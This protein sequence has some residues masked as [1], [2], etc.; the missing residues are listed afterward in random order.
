[1]SF[2]S[3]LRAAGF[4]LREV[5]ADGRWRRCATGDKPYRRNGAYVLYPDGRGY[6]RNWA[7]DDGVNAWTSN[8]ATQARPIDLARVA[9]QRER[10][11]QYRLQAIRAARAYWQA[12][13]PMH[14]PHPYIE[15]KGLTQLG[16]A[17]LRQHD[18][19]IV[20]PVWHDDRIISVQTIS[21]DG[22][23]RFWPGAP[24]KSG[25]LMLKRSKAG[26]TVFV[27]GLATGL[28]VFQSVRT[29]T[30]AVC[31]DA[32]NLLPVVQR[33]RP[34]GMLCIAADNDHGTQAR[35]GVNPGIAKAKDAA[36][37]VGAGVAWPTGIEG[38]D[39]ADLLREVGQRGAR[40]I[41]RE[42]VNAARYVADTAGSA[43]R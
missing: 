41:E 11:R 40:R 8:V 24:V 42:I 19:S 3:A 28:A 1:M 7:L 30:V 23:K 34:A 43:K 14:R 31:F 26:I 12:A 5:V 32:G 21:P 18:G 10:E 38:T 9:H 16:C 20:V 6:F 39:F 37:L 15:R 4:Q 36:A 27:E 22:E 13:Q 33:L 2:E 25:A 17:G 35:C 29:A